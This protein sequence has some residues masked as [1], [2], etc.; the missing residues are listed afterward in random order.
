MKRVFIFSVSVLVFIT[1]MYLLLMREGDQS[2]Y[3]DVRAQTRDQ[4]ETV[5]EESEAPVAREL[6]EH[7]SPSPAVVGPSK[8]KTALVP[9][10]RIDMETRRRLL[11]AILGKLTSKDSR[12]GYALSDM[13]DSS[14]KKG[15]LKREYIQ[16]RMR[17][18]VPLVKECYHLALDQSPDLDGKI[19]VEFSIVGDPE[20]GGLIEK[21]EVVD[22]NL[23]GD[24][25]LAEC[26]RETMYALRL[27]AP[28]GG[29]RVVVKYPFMF[30]S[31]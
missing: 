20:L 21:S 27:D 24:E 16:E 2:E 8:G 6:Q 25:T 18:I 19:V 30:R 22:G 11:S 10:A 1:A 31:K 5:S 28:E 3:V 14:G 9:V 26:L 15:S 23:A 4:T 17:E 29:G 7:R 12:T 13:K